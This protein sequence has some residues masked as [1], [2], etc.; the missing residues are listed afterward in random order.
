MPPTARA[1]FAT[2]RGVTSNLTDVWLRRCVRADVILARPVRGM[3]AM[4]KVLARARFG[5]RS[6]DEA[7]RH[8][9]IGLPCSTRAPG[10]SQRRVEAGV[11]TLPARFVTG[12]HDRGNPRL[13]EK[14]Y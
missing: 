1:G 11:R 6:W 7:V 5:A 13:Q 3:L 4:E 14:W 9:C 2:G 8:H 10:V 12:S